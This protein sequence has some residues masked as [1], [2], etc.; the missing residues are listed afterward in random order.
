M[1]GIAGTSGTVGIGGGGGGGGGFAPATPTPNPIAAPPIA[2]AIAQLATS[3][4]RV[5]VRLSFYRLHRIPAITGVD[6]SAGPPA[7]RGVDAGNSAA[8]RCVWPFRPL[9]WHNQWPTPRFR[10]TAQGR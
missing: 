1:G 10:F 8:D 5:I 7:S 2:A 4:F 6:T 3:F 9:N